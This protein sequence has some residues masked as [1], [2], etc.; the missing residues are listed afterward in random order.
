LTLSSRLRRLRQTFGL[1]LALVS[2]VV[3]VGITYQG[4][5]TA[6][7]RRR[8]ERPGGLVDAGGHQLHIVCAGEGTPLVVLE[9]AAGAMSSA[10]GWVQPEIAMRTRVC[11]YDRSGLGWSEAG[12]GDY[13]PSR[14]PEQLHALLRNA[15]ESGPM[16]LVGHELGASFARIYAGRYAGAVTA[17][18]LVDE[19]AARA[20][21]PPL[22]SAWPWLARAG[23]L[24]A[25]RSLTAMAD[26][27]PGESGQAMRAFL[28]RPDHL[29][30]AA[31]ELSRRREVEDAARVVELD[32][33]IAITSVSVGV[34]TQ[35]AMFVEREGAA[36]VSRAIDETLARVRSAG[37]GPSHT[38]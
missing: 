27:L 33:A 36:K 25:S 22:V 37:A 38:P 7:E 32:A 11:A 21:A 13:V 9:A 5:A 15:G 24:R 20:P 1:I 10:W 31:Q 19:A 23:A 30:R 2:I 29:T 16:L 28:N 3:L 12:D 8:V 35:P 26:G 17:L 34:G 6:L 4:V 14:V 18:V